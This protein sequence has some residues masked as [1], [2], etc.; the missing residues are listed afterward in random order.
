MA[1]TRSENDACRSPA[2]TN[3]E[4]RLRLARNLERAFPLPDSGEF[5]DLLS[6]LTRELS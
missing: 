5:K 6:A 3:R 4:A 1:S 2:R